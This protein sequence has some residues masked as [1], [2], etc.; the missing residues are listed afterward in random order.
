MA[1]SDPKLEPKERI[2]EMV[3]GEKVRK[4]RKDREEENLSDQ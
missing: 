2:E 3:S 4:D 1:S